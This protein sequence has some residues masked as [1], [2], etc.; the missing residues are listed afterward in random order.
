[1]DQ[2]DCSIIIPVY[3]NEGSLKPTFNILKQKV[4]DQNKDKTWEIIFVDD[5]SGDNSFK[6]LLEIK[7]E[8]KES[9]K[10]IKFTRNFGQFYARRAGMEFS[11]GRCIIHTSADLQDPAELINDMIH[12]HFKKNFEIVACK[13]EGREESFYRRFTSKIFYQLMRKLSFPNMPVGGFDYVLISE[14][15]KN[16]LLSK[17]EANP[18]LQAQILWTGYKIKF[19][20]YKR[21]KR[22]IGKSKWTFGKKLKL[23]IDGVMGYSLAPLRFMIIIGISVSLLGFIYAIYILVLRL[24]EGVNVQGWAPLMIVILILSGTQMLML[25]VIGEYLWRTLD[26]VRNRP[27]YLIEAVYD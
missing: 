22:E 26:Q 16:V 9:I 2:I 25:G 27:K 7:R 20:P 15:V 3:Y 23:L 6:E 18:F 24:V 19:I 12:Y 11:T 8:N 1:M 21:R 17:N 13:R 14:K 4:I 10:V 5:G